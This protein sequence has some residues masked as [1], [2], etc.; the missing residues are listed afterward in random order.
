MKLRLTAFPLL[1]IAFFG[2]AASNVAAQSAPTAE[3]RLGDIG[4]QVVL[5]QKALNSSPDT[6]VATNGAGS[7]GFE[8]TYFGLKT[9]DAVK[10]YQ[11]KYRTSIL[12]P[13][14]IIAP[15][16]F[17]G[18]LTLQSLQKTSIV[19]SSYSTSTATSPAPS[20]HT[21]KTSFDSY[22]TAINKL[23]IEQGYSST[24]LALINDTLRAASATTTDTVAEFYKNQQALYQKKASLEAGKPLAQRMLNKVIAAAQS[25]F[26]PERAQAAT[27]LPFGGFVTYAFPCTCTPW[28]T[29]IFVALPM[30]T[31]TS[32]FV[33]NYV[34]GTQAFGWY[35]LPTPSVAALG[36]YAP[37]VQSC[38][39]IVPKTCIP[40]PAVGTITPEVGSSLLP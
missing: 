2:A 14:G 3:L 9:L 40:L 31:A 17:V 32:N 18:P 33:L 20:V 4:P 5:L 1:C 10:R 39:L 26:A 8:S 28:V 21:T 6:A 24:T 35:T 30:P 11:A 19:S 25:I 23:G 7:P 22:I 13:A 37:G 16:G 36:S 29:S 15:T 12:M 27:G 38:Y 34:N